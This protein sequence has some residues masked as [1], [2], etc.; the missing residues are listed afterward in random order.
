MTPTQTAEAIGHACAYLA[1]DLAANIT[2]EALTVVA[3]NAREHHLPPDITENSDLY[4]AYR[5]CR[6]KFGSAK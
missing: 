6:P 4:Q 5:S 2:G 1:S 3:D